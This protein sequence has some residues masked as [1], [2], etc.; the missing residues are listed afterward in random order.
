M[1]SGKASGRRWSRDFNFISNKPFSIWH[2]GARVWTLRQLFYHPILMLHTVKTIHCGQFMMQSNNDSDSQTT[3]M[4][5]SGLQLNLTICPAIYVHNMVYIS[6]EW[7]S[8]FASYAGIVYLII[9]KILVL[10]KIN[11]S[12]KF[13]IYYTVVTT[14]TRQGEWTLHEGLWKVR[15]SLIV[16]TTTDEAQSRASEEGVAIKDLILD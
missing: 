15:S 16:I 11:F 12:K 5:V 2:R 10:L 14:D 7:S 4:L 1:I 6:Q 8:T 13:T 9:P 3:C